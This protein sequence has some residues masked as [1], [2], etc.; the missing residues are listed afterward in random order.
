MTAELI[1]QVPPERRDELYS[2]ISKITQ[3]TAALD[4][5]LEPVAEALDV[6]DALAEIVEMIGVEI[7]RARRASRRRQPVAA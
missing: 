1:L 7:R 6:D 3:E 4:R 2:R 5:S